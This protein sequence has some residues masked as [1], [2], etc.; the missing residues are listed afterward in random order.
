MTGSEYVIGRRAGAGGGPVGERHALVAVAT[1]KD[2]PYRAECGATVDMVDGDWPPEG[3]DEHACPGVRPRHGSP[4]G[5]RSSSRRARALRRRAEAGAAQEV[6][7]R[8]PARHL[9]GCTRGLAPGRDPRCSLHPGTDRP[10]GPS[11]PVASP[12]HLPVPARLPAPVT[13]CPTGTG[14]GWLARRQRGPGRRRRMC[15]TGSA[16]GPAP[17]PPARA[18]VGPASASVE[19]AGMPP[20]STTGAPVSPVTTAASRASPMV[21]TTAAAPRDMRRTARRKED[22]GRRCLPLLGRSKTTVSCSSIVRPSRPVT[23]EMAA[24]IRAPEPTGGGPEEGRRGHLTPRHRR[25]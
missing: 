17:M 23:E 25:G 19:G 6:R 16:V 20:R 13:R 14:V 22:A 10:A 11:T 1:R 8:G 7:Q 5:V 3:G 12:L 21:S 4:L 9:A 2:G 15:G 18:E 24:P